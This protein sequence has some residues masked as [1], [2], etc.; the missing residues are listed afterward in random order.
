MRNEF[1]AKTRE[2][3]AKRVAYRC[4][5]PECRKI[6]SG[7]QTD[8]YAVVNIGVAAHITAASE[9]GPRFVASLTAAERGSINNGIWLCQSCAKL[10]DNDPTRYSVDILRQWKALAES[11]TSCE[12]GSRQNF[13]IDSSHIFL[14]LERLMNDNPLCREF[15]LLK[16]CWAYNGTGNELEYYYDDHPQLDNKILILLNHDLIQDV[17]HS[18]VSRFRFSETFVDYLQH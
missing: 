6:T 5:N 17:T 8:Q 14:K 13:D 9:S 1:T 18:N 12:L 2:T 7:P 3:L 11:S 16:K 4:S 15:V 10:I